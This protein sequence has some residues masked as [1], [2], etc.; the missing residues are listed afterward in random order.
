MGRPDALFWN[1]SLA[2]LQSQLQA[3]QGGAIWRQ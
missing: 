1:L 3:T 2:A